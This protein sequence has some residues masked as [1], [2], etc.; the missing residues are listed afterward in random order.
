MICN[1]NQ[2][3]KI[4]RQTDLQI[5][6]ESK[7][8]VWCFSIILQCWILQQSQWHLV[9]RLNCKDSQ[10]HHCDIMMI[11]YLFVR[12][13]LREGHLVHDATEIHYGKKSACSMLLI[14]CLLVVCTWRGVEQSDYVILPVNHAMVR[15]KS[16]RYGQ[17]LKL[18][19]ARSI[20][21]LCFR[22]SK[23]QHLWKGNVGP[24]RDFNPS[25]PTVNV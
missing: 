20:T 2:V 12:Q 19:T 25:L 4:Q 24:N 16:K 22:W 8:L 3:Q 21:S 14:K 1:K 5:L 7:M 18:H 9:F 15:L 11:A 10:I 23:E 6:L 13:K 17:S